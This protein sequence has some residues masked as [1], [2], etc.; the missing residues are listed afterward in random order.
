MLLTDPRL[1]TKGPSRSK[2]VGRDCSESGFLVLGTEI[3][4]SDL[5]S[6]WNSLLVRFNGSVLIV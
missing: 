3:K 1:V 4:V 6:D 5:E 2:A